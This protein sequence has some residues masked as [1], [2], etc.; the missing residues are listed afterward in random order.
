MRSVDEW[1]GKSDDTQIPLRVRIRV[2]LRGN[3]GC[4]HCGRTIRT[5]DKWQC[6]HIRALIR[7]GE[8]RESN[9]QALCD[10]CHKAKTNTDIRDK[11]IVYKKQLAHYGLRKSQRPM[12]GSKASGWKHLMNGQWVRR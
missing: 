10:P 12:M 1:I 6:D 3:R 5:G 9:L 4:A 2:L 8:N 7:G 11:S